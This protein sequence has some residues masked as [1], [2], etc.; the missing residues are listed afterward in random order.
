MTMSVRAQFQTGWA[1][2]VAMKDAFD[3]CLYMPQVEVAREVVGARDLLIV[4]EKAALHPA[5][6]EEW[7][8]ISDLNV[9]VVEALKLK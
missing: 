1:T 2:F 3:Q 5:L 6:K 7:R 8:V 9:G 4:L